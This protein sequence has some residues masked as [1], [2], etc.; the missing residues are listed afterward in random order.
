VVALAVSTA[1]PAWAQDKPSTKL[2]VSAD[3]GTA[4]QGISEYSFGI[5]VPPRDDTSTVFRVRVGYQF[6]RYFALEAGYADLGSYSNGVHMDCTGGS[7]VV[8]IPDFRSEVDLSAFHLSGVG[9]FPFGD[10]FTVRAQIGFMARR[11]ETHQVPVTGADYRRSA[12]DVMPTL[13][14][15]ASF[16][17]KPKVELYAE[18]NKFTGDEPSYG[19]VQEPPGSLMDEADLES[20][21]V[22]ARF[23]F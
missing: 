15:G 23:R 16:A 17:L 9:M 14:F 2:Y 19:A 21:S 1:A 11:K 20:F 10:R 3:V 5:A 18:W 13:G 4:K 12:T 22:G 8:C 7:Q 6:I